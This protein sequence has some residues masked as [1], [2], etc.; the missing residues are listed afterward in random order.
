MIS[1]IRNIRN[2]YNVNPKIKLNSLIIANEDI[3]L[4]SEN[5]KIIK[6]LGMLE[7]IKISEKSP[8]STDNNFVKIIVS[9]FEMYIELTKKEVN[10]LNKKK[11]KEIKFLE[12]SIN[13]IENKLNNRGFIEKAPREIIEKEQE[14]YKAF[15]EKLEKL[16]S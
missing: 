7:S 9:N 11:N 10:E 8:A 14:K 12:D 13:N 1:S 3:K 4:I 2:E 15:K 6:S 16:K 5:A